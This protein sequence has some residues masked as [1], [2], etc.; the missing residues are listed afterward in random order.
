[1]GEKYE[2]KLN[3]GSVCKQF[4]ASEMRARG[5]RRVTQ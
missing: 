2:G 4:T 5:T 1:M 3:C